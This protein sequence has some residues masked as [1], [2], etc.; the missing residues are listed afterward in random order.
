[1]PGVIPILML[2]AYRIYI[3]GMIVN[4][5]QFLRIKV[6]HAPAGCTHLW[7]PIDVG[8]NTAIK[9][10]M[11]KKSG[12]DML[13]GDGIINGTTKEPSRQLVAELLFEVY[14]SILHWRKAWMKKVYKW[15]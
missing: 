4:Q 6:I 14:V 3:I 7:Q 8:I 9:S 13:E 2:V 1:M 11:R 12:H 10:G 15:F 5:I